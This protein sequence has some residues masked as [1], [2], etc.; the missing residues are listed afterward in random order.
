MNAIKL[1]AIAILTC[2]IM[3]RV[4][5]Q[6]NESGL[7]VRAYIYFDPGQLWTFTGLKPA[8]M[9]ITQ[10]GNLTELEITTLYIRGGGNAP[11]RQFGIR[12]E[13][14]FWLFKQKQKRI[15]PSLGLAAEPYLSLSR[16]K[17]MVSRYHDTILLATYY[18]GHSHYVSVSLA[19]VPRI[20]IALTQRS[21]LDVNAVLGFVEFSGYTAKYLDPAL[22]AQQQKRNGFD[23]E[24]F[25]RY[26]TYLRLGLG[27][28]L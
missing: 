18:P 20:M 11:L 22:T 26:G 17:E 2:L 13:Y 6:A 1:F 23:V 8:I 3:N 28:R 12:G 5:A 10:K 7:A 21:F 4:L 14:G 27:V 24:A 19:A 15:A 25:P 16:R 9:W